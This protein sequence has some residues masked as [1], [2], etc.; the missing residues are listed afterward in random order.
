[1]IRGVFPPLVRVR[2]VGHVF[3]ALRVR[4]R[5]ISH[6]ALLGYFLQNAYRVSSAQSFFKPSTPDGATALRRAM[7]IVM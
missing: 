7:R 4:S 1:M 2:R 3:V 5:W 6:I